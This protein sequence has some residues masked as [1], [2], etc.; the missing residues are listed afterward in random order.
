MMKRA[1]QTDLAS[2]TTEIQE[3][4]EEYKS[5]IGRSLKGVMW[6]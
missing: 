3:L 1:S 2:M 5:S 4:A 6:K